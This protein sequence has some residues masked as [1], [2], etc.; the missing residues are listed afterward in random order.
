M[1]A[2]ADLRAWYCLSPQFYKL[3]VPSALA[4][5]IFV[6]CIMPEFYWLRRLTFRN[7]SGVSFQLNA[8]HVD[9]GLKT[10]VLSRVGFNELIRRTYNHLSIPLHRK[11]IIC[12]FHR[13]QAHKAPTCTMKCGIRYLSLRASRAASSSGVLALGYIIAVVQ[14]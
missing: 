12:N 9:A 8:R 3:P 14:K 13:M 4:R 1:G 5:K 6:T 10:Y 11:T 2:R 7:Y